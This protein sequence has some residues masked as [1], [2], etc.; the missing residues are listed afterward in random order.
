[1][2]NTGYLIS[3]CAIVFRE[4]RFDD[5]LWIELIGY[6]EV[7]G[8]IK[9]SDA[10]RALSFTVA[11]TCIGQHG[12]NGSLQHIPNQLRDTVTVTG[13][14]SAKEP[15]VQN[16]RVGQTQI[17]ERLEARKAAFGIRLI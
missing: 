11:Y 4:F 2:L 9:T 7:W 14:G 6:D 17:G 13:E 16:H 3:C 1:M 8:L 5:N 10:R 12:L 15:L